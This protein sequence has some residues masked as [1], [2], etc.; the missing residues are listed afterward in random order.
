MAASSYNHP[1][2]AYV[3]QNGLAESWQDFERYVS[4]LRERAGLHLSEQADLEAIYTVFGIPPPRRVSLPGQQGLLLNAEVGL[5]IINQDDIAARQ[6]FT[7][8]HELM[9]LLVDALPAGQGYFSSRKGPFRHTTKEQLCNQGAANLLMPPESF[10][11]ATQATSVGFS[12]ARKLADQYAV[13]TTAALVQLV[14]VV[15]GQRAV[16]AWRHKHKQT[17]K[18]R[19]VPDSQMLLFQ[20]LAPPG[21]A[22]R[23]RVEWSLSGPEGPYVPKKQ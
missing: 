20:D 16:V 6:R 21:P 8:A 9:E 10:L 14:R 22:K 18:A 13:S 1:G 23:V 2:R 12:L 17:D 15:P 5:I 11:E 7:E 3:E 4:F 19:A